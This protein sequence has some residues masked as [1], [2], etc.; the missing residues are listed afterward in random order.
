MDALL[1]NTRKT[2]HRYPELSGQEAQ[3]SQRIKNF[4][5]EHYPPSQMIDQ[6]G[7]HGLVCVYDSGQVGSHVMF[8][9]ELDALPIHEENDIKHKSNYPNIS[10]KC[11]HDGHMTILLS[12]ILWLKENIPKK[13]KVSFLFQ[14]AEETG[15]GGHLVL[16]DSR[17]PELKPDFIFALHNI[18][19]APM[20]SILQV[21]DY[22]SPAVE[23]FSLSLKG[24]TTHASSPAAGINPALAIAAIINHLEALNEADL[25]S[26][27]FQVL[28]PVCLE[29]GQKAF[30]ISPGNGSLHYTIRAWSDA[31]LDLLKSKILTHVEKVCVDQQ[32]EYQME[33]FEYFPSTINHNKANDILISATK[34]GSLNLV[35]Q[36]HPFTFGE[37][38]GWFSKKYNCA[39]F[40]L[41]AGIDTFPLHHESYDFPDELIS[42]G[43]KIFSQIIK[44][45][46]G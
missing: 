46:L 19:G 6:L 17:F 34:S 33:W 31:Q 12:T 13:G 18:P 36:A 40:G 43:T 29:M 25:L 22:F 1:L 30:G 7:G 45:I 26:K 14:P 38:F 28:T 37:D 15:Q 9:C 24:I 4:I 42:T 32:L 5:K 2:L 23:S 41:G 3:T 44:E 11:G 27:D 21:N 10:H 35:Q 20:H 16:E 39:M 8:R